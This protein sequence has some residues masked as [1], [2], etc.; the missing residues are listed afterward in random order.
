MASQIDRREVY[1]TEPQLRRRV[2]AA[3]VARRSSCRWI[4]RAD[5]TRRVR[6]PHRRRPREL[7]MANSLLGDGMSQT[8]PAHRQACASAAAAAGARSSASCSSWR[9]PSGSGCCSSKCAAG[10]PGGRSLRPRRTR[11][12]I[13]VGIAKA[14]LGDMPIT[15]TRARHGHAGGHRLGDLAR[16]RPARARCRFNEGQMVARASCWPSIDP[17][18]RSRPRWTRPRARW[19]RTRP[20]SPAPRSTSTLPDPARPELHRPPDLRGP[21]GDGAPGRRPGV[22]DQ[23]TR[24][25]RPAQP[26]LDAD[27]SRRSPAA[28]ACARS[29]PATRSPPT[30]R[31]RSRSSPRS[32]RST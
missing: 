3:G 11:P 32:T 5:L 2:T 16:H 25:H 30:A 21:G 8:H 15:V 20:T 14:T 4:K 29:T 7:P 13:T 10:G 12:T 17:G 6:G 22:A 31:R 23:G 27:C 24:G 19:P 26:R 28:S 1:C 9:S 18:A